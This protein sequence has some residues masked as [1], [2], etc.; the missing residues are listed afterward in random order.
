[1]NHCGASDVHRR[2]RP[3]GFSLVELLVVVATIGLL[4]ALLLP[5]VQAAREAGRRASCQ[6]NLRQVALAT[7]MYEQALGSFPPGMA[8]SEFAAAPVYRG[9][10][11]FAWILAHL[12]QS[13]RWAPW[14]VD[15]PLTNTS[16]G[17]AAAT[18]GVIPVFLC[19]ADPLPANPVQTTQ[20]WHQGL[21]SYGGNGGTR[22]FPPE[23]ATTDG[24]FHITGHVS[25][26]LPDQRAV[27][28][29]EVRDGTSH[30]WLWGERSHDDPN[31]ESFGA[32]GWSDRL[33]RWGWW[34][35]SAGRR[36]IGHVTLSAESAV[37]YRLPY[38]FAQ[39]DRF[40]PPVT[41]GVDFRPY[42][43]RRASAWGS[44]HPGGAQ[45]ALVDGSV[46]FVSDRIDTAA[47][48]SLATRAGE[49]P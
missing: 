14:R 47:W 33:S 16:G 9:V 22:S 12:E 3:A 49:V 31:A 5:A 11:L 25:E 8:Q 15:D 39:R 17:R 45:G 37:N 43:D 13:A 10:G 42:F 19:P 35:V 21:T 27:R 34:G 30:T 18:A 28:L 32:A 44:S 48:R 7:L 29:R 20:G 24:M 23:L 4:L 6:N 41:T 2:P 38:D 26:P 40:V 1:M 46:Q 36:A